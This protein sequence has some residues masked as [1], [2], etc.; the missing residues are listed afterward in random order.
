MKHLKIFENFLKEDHKEPDG[1]VEYKG[2]TYVE[3]N[4]NKTFKKGDLVA[5]ENWHKDD[6]IGYFVEKIAHV[7]RSGEGYAE[8]YFENEKGNPVTNLRVVGNGTGWIKL[9]EKE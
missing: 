8:V 1:N 2:K 7:K 4:D 6:F 9:K 5:S 3:D